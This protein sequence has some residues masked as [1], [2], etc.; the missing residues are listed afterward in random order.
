M[1]PKIR[2][3]SFMILKLLLRGKLL[4]VFKAFNIWNIRFKTVSKINY[5]CIIWVENSSNKF[6]I[7]C[8]VSLAS[9]RHRWQFHMAGRPKVVT[10]EVCW[11]QLTFLEPRDKR[12]K[13]LKHAHRNL[14][15]QG[16]ITSNHVHLNVTPNSP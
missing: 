5:Y 9:H 15:G 4:T 7:R 1:F 3:K 16:K 13:T 11:F 12:H 2:L 8:M 14:Q 6:N 10:K